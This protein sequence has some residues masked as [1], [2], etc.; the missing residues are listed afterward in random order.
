MNPESSNYTETDLV[1]FGTDVIEASAEQLVMVDFWA[2]WCGPCKSLAPILEKLVVQYQGVVKLVKV[3]TEQ[4]QELA[5]Q[6][7]IKSL[8]TVFFF[9]NGEV[10]DQFMG[11]QPESAIKEIINKHTISQIDA[12]LENAKL[13]YDNGQQEE[14]KAF[15]K[16]L[17]D[18]YPSDDRP[19]LLL[20]DWL[21]NEGDL[22]GAG[23]VV[24][25]ISEN[26][27]NTPEVKALNSRIEFNKE[28][29]DL[30]DAKSLI[31]KIEKDDNDLEARFQLAQRLVGEQ[32][33]E[34]GLSHLLEIV[35]RNREF[36]D[37]AARKMMIKVFELLGTK[38]EIVQKYRGMLARILN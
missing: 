31:E 10:V 30:P 9:K 15:I 3:N 2:D 17:I 7:G 35:K 32:D 29:G 16:Q 11:A 25:L 14:A 1:S 21:T 20:L 38:R 24:S 23:Q 5:G 4:Q 13:D 18:H 8:P 36:Q 19:K 28:S 26:G 33:F 34:S 6:F 27:Q 22:E 37:D 12:A